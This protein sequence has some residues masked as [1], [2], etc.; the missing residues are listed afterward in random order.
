MSESMQ[1]VI[2]ED[3]IDRRCEMR[4]MLNDRFSQ[5]DVRFFQTAGETIAYLREHLHQTLVVVLDHDLDL[6]PIDGHRPFDPGSGRDV[7]D[8]LVTQPPVCPILIHTTNSAAAIGMLTV[9]DEAGWTTHQVV[10]EGDLEWIRTLWIPAIRNAIV[11]FVG[12]V[13]VE[14][15]VR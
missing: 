12:R 14:Q 3:N 6:I 5:Y 10:P 1:I 8:F 13:P 11:G 2:L 7:A 4:A 15:V 9:L